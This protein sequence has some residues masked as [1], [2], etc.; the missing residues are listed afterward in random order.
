MTDIHPD[1]QKMIDN[2]VFS[3]TP[4][5]GWVY[6]F[7][8]GKGWGASGWMPPLPEPEFPKQT[9][10][11]N[12]RASL[13]TTISDI[14]KRLGVST[15]SA[16]Q[17]E[18]GRIQWDEGLIDTYDD[19]LDQIEEEQKVPSLFLYGVSNQGGRQMEIT[20]HSFINAAHKFSLAEGVG[21]VTLLVGMTMAD[22]SYNRSFIVNKEDKTI[23][24]YAVHLIRSVT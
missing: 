2:G 22:P 7:M 1:V 6:G 12:R 10:R 23:D 16:S 20:G 4:V 5:D 14:A 11:R 24:T 13:N 3:Y 15:A 18:F 19:I 9:E 17:F 21:K 8:D